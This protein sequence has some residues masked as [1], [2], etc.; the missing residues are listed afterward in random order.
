M[1]WPCSRCR[2]LAPLVRRWSSLCLSC[3]VDDLLD[4]V[5][6]LPGRECSAAELIDDLQVVLDIGALIQIE[7]AGELLDVDDVRQDVAVPRPPARHIG[8]SY[9]GEDFR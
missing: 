2:R 7:G 6:R 1:A 3:L 9:Q 8:L 4:E 5:P